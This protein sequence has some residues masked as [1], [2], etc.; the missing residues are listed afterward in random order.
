M[1][2]IYQNNTYRFIGYDNIKGTEVLVERGG[3]FYCL[4]TAQCQL[5]RKM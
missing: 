2:V 5:I 4:P 3:K 1:K